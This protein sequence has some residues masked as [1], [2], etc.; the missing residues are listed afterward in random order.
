MKKFSALISWCV[1]SVPS[2]RALLIKCGVY[3][4]DTRSISGGSS[5]GTPRRPLTFDC[6]GL[7]LCHKRLT[8]LVI[9]TKLW[10][11]LRQP[12][13]R[14]NAHRQW[15]NMYLKILTCCKRHIWEYYFFVTTIFNKVHPSIYNIEDIEIMWIF[16][17]KTTKNGVS[18]MN[19]S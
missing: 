3:S 15:L 9:F 13:Q 11:P 17:L 18:Q 8:D 6:S 2:V 7:N 12:M 14:Q 10:P 16:R 5:R 19:V 4:I 1:W